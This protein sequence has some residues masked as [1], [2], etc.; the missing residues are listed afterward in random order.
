MTVS[1]AL[2][3][4]LQSEEAAERLVAP[5][6]T[7]IKS[8]SIRGIANRTGFTSFQDEDIADDP[9]W[10]GEEM[11]NDILDD[12]EPEEKPSEEQGKT[13]EGI[14]EKANPQNGH[15]SHE[16]AEP[17]AAVLAQDDAEAVTDTKDVAAPLADNKEAE[18][19]IGVHPDKDNTVAEDI[20]GV[21][22]DKDKTVAAP[23]EVTKADGSQ[24]TAA[25]KQDEEAK[26]ID[27]DDEPKD[28]D[29]VAEGSGND[30]DAL[31]TE[32]K[33]NLPPESTPNEGTAL[34]ETDEC[35]SMCLSRMEQHKQHWGGDLL[36]I[37]EVERLAKEQ[38]DKFIAQLKV[39]YGEE[40]FTEIFEVDSKSRGRTAFLS[41][42]VEDGV[43]LFRFK[44]KLKMKILSAQLSIEKERTKFE[45][46]DCTVVTKVSK[47]QL[48]E[49]HE[50]VPSLADHHE[51]FVW[52]TGG[53]SIAAGH[54]NLFNQSYTAVM[55]RVLVDIFGSIGIEFEGRAYAMGGTPSAPEIALC[56]EAIFG[57]DPDVLS[58]DFAM[59]DGGMWDRKGMYTNRGAGLNP[60]R[61]ALI[62][63]FIDHDV[64]RRV[65]EL[66]KV[67]ERGL[68]GLYMNPNTF[69]EMKD[70]IPD[71]FGLTSE[72]ID[73]LPR[74]VRHFKCQDALEKGD[75]T[76][77]DMK[78]DNNEI[79]PDRKGMAFWHPGWKLLALWGNTMALFM[80]ETL[81]DAIAEIDSLSD[82][83]TLLRDLQTEENIE[84]QKFFQSDL[85]PLEKDFL[86]QIGEELLNEANVSVFFRSPSI[87]H[88]ARLPAETRYLGILTES[89]RVGVHDYYKGVPK[90]VADQLEVKDGSEMS[91][92][93]VYDPAERQSCEVELNRDFKD[94]F[95]ASNKMGWSRITIPNKAEVRAYGLTDPE[96]FKYQGLLVMCLKTCDWGMCPAGDM[97][98]ESIQRGQVKFKVNGV[99]V[100]NVTKFVD[101]GV[102]RGK[103]GHYWKPNDNGQYKIRAKVLGDGSDF[104]FLRISSLIVL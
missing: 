88:T 53:H 50:R 57:T 41:A 100:T 101:C 21:H 85:P 8:A 66:Q 11:D 60:N 71:T 1:M 35:A 59:L 74:F 99:P 95:F 14:S 43:S 34:Q 23:L 30:T 22:P 4:I 83:E 28:K 92:P 94:F 16:D 104:S 29:D 27:T 58:W 33:V 61:P 2:I 40:Y 86:N 7:V 24:K 70:G 62:D 84:Y 44:R 76:C 56:N 10:D 13:R 19:I 39:D 6:H 98:L 72:Q 5:Q 64:E 42:N 73:A 46:C 77:N 75:P 51:R 90:N 80:S 45:G 3:Y 9:L 68:T 91:M 52:A 36:D 38:Y 79:C 25:S 81:L 17:D 18:D 63:M 55:E 20:I 78:Y 102:L 54:G 96:R 87:C 93:L 15:D 12:D 47:P 49:S 26:A 67:E 69:Q 89:D 103:H 82:R 31:V 32:T 97:Q 65:E 37:S 48:L